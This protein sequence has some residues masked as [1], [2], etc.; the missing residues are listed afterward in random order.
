MGADNVLVLQLLRHGLRAGAAGEVDEDFSRRSDG[1]VDE[2]C[3]CAE[4]QENEE[5]KE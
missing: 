2:P 4:H 5:D 1:G 3:C